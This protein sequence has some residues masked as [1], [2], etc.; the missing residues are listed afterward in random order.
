MNQMLVGHLKSAD[1]FAVDS[2]PAATFVISSVK[3]IEQQNAIEGINVTRTV[4]G[5]L[6]LRGIT[7]AVSFPTQATIDG[8]VIKAVTPNLLTAPNGGPITVRD[9]YLPI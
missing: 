1:S 7:R 2:F 9:R 3:P 6:T 5:N 8:S 4:E